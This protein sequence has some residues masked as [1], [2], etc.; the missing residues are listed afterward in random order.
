VSTT[1]KHEFL[2]A[3]AHT[4]LISSN[5]VNIT[6]NIYVLGGGS[7]GTN[8]YS[9]GGASA[10][11]SEAYAVALTPGLWDLYVG[12]GAAGSTGIQQ[13]HGEDSWFGSGNKFNALCKALAKGAIGNIGGD[14]T[15]GKGD[16]KR[17]GT[18]TG[19]VGHSSGAGAPGPNGVGGNGGNYDG[20]NTATA[21]GGGGGPDGGTDG[22]SATTGVAG[23]GGN[24][25][26]AAKKGADGVLVGNVGL[27]GSNSVMA[28]W[29]VGP[30]GGGSCGGRANGG[31]GGRGAGGGGTGS[32][33]NL[34]YGIGG[35]GGDGFV[36]VELT[37]DLH[38]T[39]SQV[40]IYG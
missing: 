32:S 39:S 13:Y 5:W 26:A 2:T 31:K 6:A 33:G 40:H 35:A 4:L 37:Y 28:G 20:T 18:S 23:V 10:A 29:T 36:L 1:V 27:D 30:G 8:N 11:Y 21:T 34:N 25:F 19:D 14:A 15:I 22:T 3:G 17:S 9:K 38:Y 12:A 7:G 16:L 24:D